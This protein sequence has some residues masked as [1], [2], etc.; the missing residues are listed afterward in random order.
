MKQRIIQRDTPNREEGRSQFVG[1]VHVFVLDNAM[2]ADE[3]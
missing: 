2:E 3:S 1:E